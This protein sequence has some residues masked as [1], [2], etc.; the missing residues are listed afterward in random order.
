MLLRSRAMPK[1]A[2]K[3]VARK[4]AAKPDKPAGKTLLS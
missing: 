4:P 2:R 1:T 3:K